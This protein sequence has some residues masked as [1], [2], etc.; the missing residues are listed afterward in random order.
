[1]T[2]SLFKTSGQNQFPCV[3]GLT[4]PML[5]L[6]SFKSQERKDPLKTISTLPC[7]YSWDSSHRVLSDDYPHSRVLV[8]FRFLPHF[9]LTKLATSSIRLIGH[10]L[11]AVVHVFEQKCCRRLCHPV[12][13]G[14]QL[15]SNTV[16][17]FDSCTKCVVSQGLIYDSTHA[18]LVFD[19]LAFLKH[20]I[21]GCLYNQALADV[22]GKHG[23]IGFMHEMN[24][25]MKFHA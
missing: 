6:L 13:N 17:A 19:C 20:V 21:Y 10:S 4:L 16:P 2:Q 8:F 18:R 1:M 24:R 23:G 3:D 11:Y 25:V 5:R 9:V 7:W 12:F 15:A 22:R 14:S